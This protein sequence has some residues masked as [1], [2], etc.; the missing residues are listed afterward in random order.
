M[1]GVDDA[2]LDAWGAVRWE[3]F[4]FRSSVS[5]KGE[6]A[7]FH[8]G[9]VAQHVVDAFEGSGLDACGYGI[10]CHE[11]RDAREWDDEVVVAEA[12]VDEAGVEHPAETRVDHHSEEAVDL[13]MVRY[14]EALCMEAAYMRREN[15]RLKKRVA[16]LEERLA[17]LE[18]K[19]S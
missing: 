3:Q 4:K 18:L 19:V 6:S 17:A 15:A 1:A 9:L 2:F 8:A 5:E 10:L 11:L 13:W 12:Y 7:R 16:D 14:E